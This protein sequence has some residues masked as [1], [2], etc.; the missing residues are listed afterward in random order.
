MLA[1]NLGTSNGLSLRP[2]TSPLPYLHHDTETARAWLQLVVFMLAGY[3]GA[4][5]GLRLRPSASP[6]PHSQH[7]TVNAKAWLQQVG[8]TSTDTEQCIVLQNCSGLQQRMLLP[9][10]IVPPG[11]KELEIIFL[12]VAIVAFKKCHFSFYKCQ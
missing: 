11:K 12:F 4:S 5:Y 1:G 6:T 10:C 9:A 3:L 2:L 8:V 7:N